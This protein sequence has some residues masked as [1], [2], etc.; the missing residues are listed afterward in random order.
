MEY[1]WF[2]ETFAR[3]KCYRTFT[4]LGRKRSGDSVAHRGA[5]KM[6]GLFPRILGKPWDTPGNR[7]VWTRSWETQGVQG[8]GQAEFHPAYGPGMTWEVF[9]EPASESRCC[10]CV[11]DCKGICLMRCNGLHDNHYPYIIQYVH[12]KLALWDEIPHCSQTAVSIWHCQQRAEWM[13]P[14]PCGI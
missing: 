5:V 8:V 1:G 9:T 12:G 10:W 7:Q 3:S 11:K 6:P 13:K 4:L 2:F 14:L